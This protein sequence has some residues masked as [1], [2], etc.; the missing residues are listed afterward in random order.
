MKP[1]AIIT[2][3]T[4]TGKTDSAI[5]FALAFNGEIVSA[6]SMLVYRG[7]DIGTAKPSPEQRAAVPHHMIDVCDPRQDYSA[8]LWQQGALAA[9][10]DILHRDKL[11]VVVGGTGLYIQ[12]VLRPMAFSSAKG[13]SASRE[14]WTS[15][16]AQNGPEVLH[17]RL[18]A[19]DPE[20]AARLP[21]GDTRRVIRALEIYDETG[22]TMT[23][24]NRRDAARP[25]RYEAVCMGVSLERSLL[26]ARIEAR[27]DSMMEQGLVQEVDG[28]LRG[29]VP[30]NATSMQGLGYKEIA[31]YLEGELPLEAAVALLKQRTRHFAKRQVTWFKKYGGVRWLESQDPVSTAQ[32]LDFFTQTY[33]DYT[34]GVYVT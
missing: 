4:A 30:K 24:Q 13:Q 22:V 3:P 20:S 9:I 19:I 26:Y 5:D 11:P 6:D 33:L 1:I 2:G 16:L 8:A 28:L 18:E 14:K 17:R 27:V 23:E 31:A 7:M 29:G 12:A 15:Y 21:Q 10:E 25:P 34:K 32:M